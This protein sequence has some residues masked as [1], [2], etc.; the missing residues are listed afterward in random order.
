[1]FLNSYMPIQ[2][3]I[4]WQCIF[5]AQWM[6]LSVLYLA[7]FHNTEYNEYRYLFE[8]QSY[9]TYIRLVAQPFPLLFSVILW[10]YQWGKSDRKCPLHEHFNYRVDIVTSWVIFIPL[11]E[12]REIER[13]WIIPSKKKEKE[14]LTY[15]ISNVSLVVTTLL[16]TMQSKENCHV[17]NKQKN[18]KEITKISNLC[19]NTHMKPTS[20]IC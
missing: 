5:W 12:D 14:L 19:T 9:P 6:I 15:F 16:L 11:I 3:D 2:I 8:Y 4:Y 10:N 1:M 17:F 18:P 20:N 13:W 7:I